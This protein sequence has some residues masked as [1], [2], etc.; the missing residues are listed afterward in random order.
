[1]CGGRSP[2]LRPRA[3]K[4]TLLP[5]HSPTPIPTRMPMPTTMSLSDAYA[6]ILK[7]TKG[8]RSP[9]IRP[10]AVKLPNRRIYVKPM[11]TPTMPT[12]IP[13]PTPTHTQNLQ[14]F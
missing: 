13:Q 7:S 3:V 4:T 6:Y 10:K 9:Q 8:E 5:E 12:P 1:M 2:Q 14:G 11:P